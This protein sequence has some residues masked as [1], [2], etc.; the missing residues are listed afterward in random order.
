MSISQLSPASLAAN[1]PYVNPSERTSE[2]LVAGL[3]QDDQDARKTAKALKSDTVTIS[4][5]AL[6]MIAAGN[7]KKPEEV[8]ENKTSD[9]GGVAK[10]TTSVMA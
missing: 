6:Q 4:P 9:R 8:K 2:N 7:D 5:Q 1:N 10:G 3:P